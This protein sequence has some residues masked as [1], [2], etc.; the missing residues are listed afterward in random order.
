L[1]RKGSRR[2]NGTT[3]GFLPTSVS[4]HLRGSET[5]PGIMKLS[6]PTLTY[7]CGKQG[8]T[9]RHRGMRPFHSRCIMKKTE[10]Q[11]PN[12]NPRISNF[13]APTRSDVRGSFIDRAPWRGKGDGTDESPTDLG[14]W[15]P[16]PHGQ[17]AWLACAVQR[18]CHQSC[19]GKGCTPVSANWTKSAGG[20][21]A[22]SP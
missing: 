13:Q 20:S 17:P 12:L 21:R 1:T 7:P 3:A 4:F 14:K 15:R 11:P 16:K 5:A 18:E 9:S 22:Q 19:R 8:P 2:I 10:S 6:N